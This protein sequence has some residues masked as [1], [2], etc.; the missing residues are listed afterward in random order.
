MWYRRAASQGYQKA[1]TALK[2]LEASVPFKGLGENEKNSLQINPDGSIKKRLAK[3]KQLLDKGL[4][5]PDEAEG[6]RKEIL[7]SL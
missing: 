6:K 3:V 7:D 5:T 2:E 1:A 4:I